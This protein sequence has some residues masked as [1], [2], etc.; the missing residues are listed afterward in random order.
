MRFEKQGR[1]AENK[2]KSMK[3]VNR[4]DTLKLD[5]VRRTE[6]G[7]LRFDVYAG[8]T[9]IQKYRRVDGSVIREYRPAEEVF[10]GET[11]D[12]LRGAPL[13]DDHP[14]EFVTPQNARDLMR[15]FT[16]DTIE[17]VKSDKE[18]GIEFQKTS[19]TVTDQDTIDKIERG[20]VEVSLGYRVQLDETPG[21]FNGERYDF[22]QTDILVNHLALVDKARGGEEVRLRLDGDAI[23]VDED[24]SYEN[25]KEDK[26]KVKIGDR[27]F[28]V[29][30]GLGKAIKGMQ[31]EMSKLKKKM[32]SK[33]DNEADK[34]ELDK[35][36]AK[37]DHLEEELVKAK[38]SAKTVNL[39]ALKERRKLEKVAEKCLDEETFKK[40]DEM[41]E[42]DIRKAVIEA[43][44]PNVKLDGK[45]EVYIEARFD[46]I[47][48]TLDTSQKE[49][50]EAG[51][52]VSKKRKEDGE[53]IQDGS[54]EEQVRKK[55]E[56]SMKA[57]T[58]AWKQPVG[59]Y[60]KEKF[61]AS[62]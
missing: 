30:D 20:K 53:E 59:S 6:A 11:L 7:F 25:P 60:S 38:E 40:I 51:E 55:R 2:K 43:E 61:G 36:Q 48:E 1:F 23:L 46:Q 37:V 45:S 35:L 22:R 13:T 5:G 31:D 12:S 62:A 19:V 27:E 4:F 52:T 44:C 42:T 15:G 49:H 8:R 17:R 58:E 39:D 9:G 24:G 21:E 18:P 28:D 26:M 29:E 54:E 14:K 34:A 57:D 56:A 47:A 3:T 50:E 16:G 33:G 32:E 10:R 41:S